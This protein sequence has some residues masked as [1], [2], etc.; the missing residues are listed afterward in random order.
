MLLAGKGD[1]EGS[2]TVTPMDE[3]KRTDVKG[4][5]RRRRGK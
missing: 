5:A 2:S 4:G 3:G 1:D